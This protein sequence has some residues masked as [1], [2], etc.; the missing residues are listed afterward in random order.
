[1]F[2]PY[3][4][5]AIEKTVE[6]L[7]ID[8]PTGYTAEAAEYV[9]NEFE[10]LGYPAFITNKGGVAATL[11]GKD[12]ENALLIQAH[13]DTLGG[14]VR[15]IKDNGRLTIVPLGGLRANSIES[16]NCRII[17]R[18]NGSYEG[19]FALV[20]PSIHVNGEFADTK[21]D[22]DS[23][24]VTVDEKVASAED[25]KK[26]G[27]SAGDIVCFE[28]RTRVTRSGYIKSRFLDDKLS[29]GIILAFAKYLKEQKLEPAQK[30]YVHITVYEEVGHGASAVPSAFKNIRDVLAIDMGCVG[31]KLTCT[32]RQVSICAKDRSGPYSYE[33]VQRLV[34]AA[35]KNG[36]DFAVDI[37]PFYSS[38]ASATMTG[39]LDARHGLIGPGV[40]ASH[41]YE[42]SHRDGAENTLKLLAG[43]V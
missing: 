20:N 29:V 13:I 39:G 35:E 37:Y 30:I 33:M 7:A 18:K 31:E 4:D 8:S 42:R 17:T 34:N 15:H 23:C 22:F 25:V 26:L 27:I 3:T 6:L 43:L 41:G 21:R 32:E 14:M 38:D 36:A 19:T 1:M 40:F 5:Y 28:P 16:E 9:K 2:K 24:E 11:G 10:A 12:E